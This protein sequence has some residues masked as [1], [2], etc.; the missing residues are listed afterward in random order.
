MTFLSAPAVGAGWFW[1]I[2]GGL[3]LIALSGLLYQ[4]SIGTGFRDARSH[5]FIGLFTVFMVAAHAF[6]YLLGDGVAARYLWPPPVPFHMLCGVAGFLLL[7]LMTT[8]A[9]P[10]DRVRWHR[11]H[12]RF[13]QFHRALSAIVIAATLCHILGSGLYFSSWLEVTLLLTL[14]LIAVLA[15]PRMLSHMRPLPPLQA[16]TCIISSLLLVALFAMA[17]N[18]GL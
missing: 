15:A 11:S 9:M 10:G 7:T 13:R 6:W 12:R 17:R 1:D 3:G 14:A 18:F 4:A 5:Q 8:V 2:G 16:G